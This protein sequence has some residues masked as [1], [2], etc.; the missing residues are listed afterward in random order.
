[1]ATRPRPGAFGTAVRLAREWDAACQ[2]NS[3]ALLPYLGT[4]S[5]A[6]DLDRLRAA[7]G[8]PKLTFFGGSYATYVGTVY[9]SMFPGRT[10]ALVLDSAYDPQ[11]R[12]H[13]GL[14]VRIP[15]A[16]DRPAGR[17]GVPRRA[18]A[19]L[20]PGNG[21]AARGV[22]PPMT[23]W[24]AVLLLCVLSGCGGP[25]APTLPAIAM[26]SH[27]GFEPIA[28]TW[29][30]APDGAW[31]WVRQVR[32]P[33]APELSRTGRLT[34][35]QRRDLANLAGDLLLR[36]ELLGGHRACGVSD[37]ATERLEVGSMKYL[38]GWCGE[39][40]P[41]IRRLRARIVAVTTGS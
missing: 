33:G 7:V 40:R 18:D 5:Q 13:R 29:T 39:N 8:D 9:A 19:G 12:L 36:R 21:R 35:R 30:I 27:G 22:R 26:T 16:P 41:H 25:A 28:E 32:M 17:H 34:D 2:A 37:G 20:T 1:V 14:H 38:A 3:G 11:E 31:T 10:R 15:A 6:R 4:A 23:R 24:V